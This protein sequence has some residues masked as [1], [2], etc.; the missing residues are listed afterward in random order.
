MLLL[1]DPV[2][3]LWTSVQ[4]DFGGK[5]LRSLSQ[6]EVDFS[7]VPLVDQGTTA[8]TSPNRR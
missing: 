6:G 1:T 2:D 5:P 7:L 3:A 4:L 8:V